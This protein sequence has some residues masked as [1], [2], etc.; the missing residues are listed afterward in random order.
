[1]PENMH[2]ALVSLMQRCWEAC[3][4]KRPSFT[5]ICAELDELLRQIQV[6]CLFCE[7]SNLWTDLLLTYSIFHSYFCVSRAEKRANWVRV[8]PS[9][10]NT[11][12]TTKLLRLHIFGGIRLLFPQI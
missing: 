10:F 4:A 1:M 9:N 7:L 6:Q 8:M 11:I 12:C 2:P 3:P 5:E